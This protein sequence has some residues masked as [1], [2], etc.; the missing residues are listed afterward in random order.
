MTRKYKRGDLPPLGKTALETEVRA[1]IGIEVGDTV[2]QA[3]QYVSIHLLDFSRARNLTVLV[4]GMH[5][6]GLVAQECGQC[7]KDHQNK[8]SEFVSDHLVGEGSWWRLYQ[9]RT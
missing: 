8:G 1:S 4:Q 5:L 2:L 9:R 3:C 6:R 7:S